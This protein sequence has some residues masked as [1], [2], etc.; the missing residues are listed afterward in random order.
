MS[1][2]SVVVLGAGMSLQVRYPDTFGLNGL[3]WDALDADLAARADLARRLKLRDEPAKA[4]VGDDFSKWNEAWLSVAGSPAARN[5]FQR[6]FANLD[7]YR[8]TRPSAS[9]E[10]LARLI[11]SGDA[12]LV[13]S[14]NWDS[15]LER[16]YERIY[17]VAIPARILQKPHGDVSQPDEPWVL[18]HEDG[19]VGQELLRQL[20]ELADEYPRTLIVVGYSESDRAV[21]DNL[22]TPLDTRWR[23]C[24]CGPHVEGTDDIVGTADEVLTALAKPLAQR[25]DSCV[26]KVVTFTKQ[27]GIDAALEGRRLSAADVTACPTLPEV[28][29][30]AD[31]LLRTFAVVINGASGSG[32][33]IT[34]YQVANRLRQKGYEILR[35]RDR[36]RSGSVRMDNRPCPVH[37]SEGPFR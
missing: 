25:E 15:A 8:A 1:L 20:A 19:F 33:S 13:I 3:L 7:S 4:L 21:V 5:R 36:G 10:V 23:T 18:P 37:R 17:G 14:F 31:A 11:H 26:W 35:L 22:I 32:K 28:D 30:V 6:G 9:H 24:R 27:R 2:G 16:A 29:L 34:A 12:E